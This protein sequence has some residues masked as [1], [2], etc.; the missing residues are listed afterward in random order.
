MKVEMPEKLGFL[1]DPYRYKIAHGGRAGGKSWAFAMALLILGAKKP[2][3][4][5]CTR[6]VQK[7][8]KDSVHKLLQDQIVALGF[9]GFYDVLET[10][11]RGR[12]GTEIFFAGL[13]TQT[14]TSIKSFEGVDICW[15]EEAQTIRK[16]SWDILVPTIRAE[17]SEI[18]VSLNPD[19]D[20]DET[21][22]RFVLS[23]PKN[24]YVEQ[25]NY[26]DNPWF[27]NV[28]EA[29]REHCY[30]TDREDY[31]NIWLGEPRHA[32]AGAIYAG[33]VSQAILDGR[34][35][36]VPYDPALKVHTV[37]DLGWNDAMS[38]AFVQKLRSELRIIDYIE[39]SHKTLDYYIAEIKE[40]RYNWGYD[41]LPHDGRNKDF[42][43]GKS[44]F[45]LL[46]AFGRDPKITPSFSVEDGIKQGRMAFA[47]CVF[48]K[49]KAERLLECLKRYQRSVNQRTEEAGAPLHNQYAHGA[50]CFRYIAIN[51]EAMINAKK[52]VV[53][54]MPKF[55]PSVSSMGM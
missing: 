9:E 49:K 41:F 22:Q 15:C 27:P 44:T 5:L 34:V 2:L 3:R 47:Q 13:S 43:T 46:Q 30:L 42:K 10:V 52:K 26:T 12:N 35:V 8:I 18:W 11:I 25:I 28:L 54:S 37:W 20:T 21:Y 48:D 36:N 55:Q 31:N 7:S 29:E 17:D 4:I 24:S 53:P 23:P 1:F 50:D 32:V 38:I 33:E 51:A 19:L 6:E 16:K 39:D 45:E 14:V 40:R